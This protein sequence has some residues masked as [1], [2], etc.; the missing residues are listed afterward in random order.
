MR[1]VAGGDLA[2]DPSGAGIDHVHDACGRGGHQEPSA[3]RRDR[4]VV[5]P[6]RRSSCATRFASCAGLSP[7]SAKLGREKY[8]KRPSLDVKPSSTYWLWPSPTWARMKSKKVF[9]VGFEF[10]LRDPL[11]RI[12]DH[13]DPRQS[14]ERARIDEVRRPRPVV[15]QPTPRGLRARPLPSDCADAAG[16]STAI[17]SARLRKIDTSAR[18][19]PV[20]HC[21]SLMV[22]EVDVT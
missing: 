12:G 7:T 6:N 10:Y 13:V 2:D 11:R 8:T 16:A 3:V 5:G 1:R 21:V 17:P 18:L 4:H 20:P 22:V 19:K 15:A 14:P 9:A